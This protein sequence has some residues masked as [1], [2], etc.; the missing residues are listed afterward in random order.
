[1]AKAAG[2]GLASERPTVAGDKLCRLLRRC[3]AAGAA[4]IMEILALAA[5]SAALIAVLVADGV[6]GIIFHYA[7][8]TPFG[9]GFTWSFVPPLQ[10]GVPGAYWYLHI[11]DSGLILFTRGVHWLTA[12][13][14]GS[15]QFTLEYMT[16]FGS[17]F[18]AAQ[19]ALKIAAVI[20]LLRARTDMRV[21]LAA[22]AFLFTLSFVVPPYADSYSAYVNTMT[23]F[24]IYVFVFAILLAYAI[25]SEL[26]WLMRHKTRLAVAIGAFSGLL[27]FDLAMWGWLT[28]A[29]LAVL[30]ARLPWRHALRVLLVSVAVGLPTA[31]AALYAAQEGDAGAALF[32][33]WSHLLGFMPGYTY[34]EPAFYQHFFELFLNAR[35]SLFSEQ[36]LI[37]GAGTLLAVALLWLAVDLIAARGLRPLS[38]PSAAF[39]GVFLLTGAAYWHVLRVH[40]SGTVAQ[41]TALAAVTYL[42]FRPLLQ[43]AD[44]RWPRARYAAGLMALPAVAAVTFLAV[45]FSPLAAYLVL[46]AE[47]R[48]DGRVVQW[49]DRF[50]DDCA[51]HY[52][53]VNTPDL[54]FEINTIAYHLKN[55]L[56]TMHRGSEA[57]NNGNAALEAAYAARIPRYKLYFPDTIIDI[58]PRCREGETLPYA[59]PTMVAG[60]VVTCNTLELG[61]RRLVFNAVQ[62]TPAAGV[63]HTA[64]YY[65]LPDT[66]GGAAFEDASAHAS[67]LDYTPGKCAL[68]T[69]GPQSAA[70]E[71]L[72]EETSAAGAPSYGFQAMAVDPRA[73]RKRIVDDE[74]R[75]R[76]SPGDVRAAEV[77]TAALE[78]RRRAMLVKISGVFMTSYVLIVP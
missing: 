45:H 19:A 60:P 66:L 38:R 43:P 25:G 78:K 24:V 40:G 21:K 51:Q 69:A 77:A 68:L 27:F 70:A 72:R 12:T 58:G 22:M 32:A 4:R 42:F 64:L 55:L 3:K 9:E 47:Q 23:F 31:V 59:S 75:Y 65:V 74:A 13:I 63:E 48:L 46:I 33:A 76:N 54:Y 18:M 56:I 29:T 15:G 7:W 67:W 41:A 73:M 37:V 28:L 8:I 35:S 14:L 57:G 44:F 20:V 61:S 16:T 1:M 53:V 52:T 5:L 2:S 49:T 11:G 50:F 36:V 26:A 6:C 17:V 34:A 30:C 71:G 39:D 62:T 10:A